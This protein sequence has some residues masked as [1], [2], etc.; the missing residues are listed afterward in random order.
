MK[1]KGTGN[2]DQEMVLK[3]HLVTSLQSESY[4]IVHLWGRIGA[5][6]EG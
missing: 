5:S 1:R 6:F 2:I 4:R 3:T